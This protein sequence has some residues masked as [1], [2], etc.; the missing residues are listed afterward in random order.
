MKR[1]WF[2]SHRH[3]S[4]CVCFPA[5]KVMRES[6]HATQNKTYA[7]AIDPFPGNILANVHR[8]ATAF[9]ATLG[10]KIKGK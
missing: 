4:L 9:V 2:L 3:V 10:G 8:N 5:L 7:K 6:A 1:I